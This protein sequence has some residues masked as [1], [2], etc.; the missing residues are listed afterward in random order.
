[1]HEKHG[2]HRCANQGAGVATL[3][4]FAELVRRIV[5]IS[6]GTTGIA[7]RA[8][9]AVNVVAGGLGNAIAAAGQKIQIAVSSY[10]KARSTTFNSNRDFTKFRT[11]S[12]FPQ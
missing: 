12:C 7:L 11:Y 9:V 10:L 4:D 8:P 6:G 1:M 3:V 5:E 2:I